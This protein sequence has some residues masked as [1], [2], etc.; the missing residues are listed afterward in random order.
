MQVKGGSGKG[1]V[2]FV[3]SKERVVHV[4]KEGRMGKVWKGKSG[5]KEGR[6][7]A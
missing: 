7:V 5:G 4:G 2:G 3:C 1:F 6:G